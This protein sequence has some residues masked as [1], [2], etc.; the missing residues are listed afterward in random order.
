[1][2]ANFVKR[3]LAY[4]V[5]VII[6]SIIFSVITIGIS[7]TKVDNLSEQLIEVEENYISGE[8]EAIDAVN[9][10]ASLCYEIEKSS[11]VSNSIYVLLLMVYFVGFQYMNKGQTLGKM[12][13]KIKIVENEGNPSLMAMFIR[14]MFTNEI[15]INLFIILLVYVLKDISYFVTYEVLFLLNAVFMLIS[16]MMILYRK[17]KLGLHDM[18][19]RTSVVEV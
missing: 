19:S 1:M 7:T 11:V 17:D 3:V 14:T 6:V 15:L 10:M 13:V 8:L 12:L 9:K 18:L 16:G 4:F 5:D 2:R